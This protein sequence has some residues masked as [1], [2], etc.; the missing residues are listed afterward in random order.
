[1]RVPED[2]RPS[3]GRYIQRILPLALLSPFP[4][5]FRFETRIYLWLYDLFGTL[6]QADYRVVTQLGLFGLWK[7][8]E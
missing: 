3:L 4:H 8:F 1:M 5:L 2:R 6:G 7:P